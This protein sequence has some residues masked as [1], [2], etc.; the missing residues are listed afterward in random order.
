VGRPATERRAHHRRHMD[1][2]IGVEGNEKLTAMTGVI[3]LLGFAVEG[4]TILSIHS[5]IVMHFVVGFVLIGPVVLKIAST[6][7]R[8]ARYY[9]GSQPYVRK[10]PPAPIQRVLGPLVVL[11]S[12]AVLGTGVILALVGPGNGGPWL[13]LHKATFVLWFGAMTIHVLSYVPKLP[14]MLSARQPDHGQ[15]VPGRSTR[16]LALTA[17][18]AAGVGVAAATIHMSASWSTFYG[19]FH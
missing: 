18:L 6:A 2:I 4:F 19:G 3:L 11:T 14:R 7:Y 5:L 15:P 12:V 16:W 10:G 8:F 9:T 17:A 1:T 13:F